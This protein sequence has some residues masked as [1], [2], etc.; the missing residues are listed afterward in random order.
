MVTHSSIL[1]WA[2]HRI[3]L[4]RVGAH[5]VDAAEAGPTRLGERRAFI[6]VCGGGAGDREPGAAP[7]GAPG[8]PRSGPEGQTPPSACVPGPKGLSCKL[9]DY[10]FRLADKVK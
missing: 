9:F 3:P 5:R 1:A 6:D 8:Q 10:V 4:A 7:P 2:D